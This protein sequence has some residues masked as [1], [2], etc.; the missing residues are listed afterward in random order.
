MSVSFFLSIAFS[1]VNLVSCLFYVKEP[2]FV[3]SQ[4]YTLPTHTFMN[5]IIIMVKKIVNK[6]KMRMNWGNLGSEE[7]PLIDKCFLISV[8]FIFVLKSS[9]YQYKFSNR[10]KHLI[11]GQECCFTN[12]PVGEN[13]MR[14]RSPSLYLGSNTDHWLW[15]DVGNMG[16]V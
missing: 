3:I 11:L 4:I 5:G 1:H 9:D 2:L 13:L 10:N 14:I 6:F 7:P 12:Y 16:K 15:W 8:I